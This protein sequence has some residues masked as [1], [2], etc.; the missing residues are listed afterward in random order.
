[1]W[2]RGCYENRRLLSQS[3]SASLDHQRALRG[4]EKVIW[5]TMMVRNGLAVSTF[6][7]QAILGRPRE[8]NSKLCPTIVFVSTAS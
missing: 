6:K 5:E 4:A 8:I 2:K 1:M 3:V 7:Q